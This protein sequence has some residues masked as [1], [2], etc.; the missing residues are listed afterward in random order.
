MRRVGNG[1]DTFF[2]TDPWLGGAPL[3]VRFRRLSNMAQNN[4]ITVVDMCGLGWE[5]GGRLGSGAV[6]CG[7]GRSSC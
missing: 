7:C 3:C 6:G 4:S 2:W 1:A 5:E